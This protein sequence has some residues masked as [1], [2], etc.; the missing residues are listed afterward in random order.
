MFHLPPLQACWLQT[1][2]KGVPRWGGI[3]P[4]GLSFP[5]VTQEG[6][7]PAYLSEPTSQ[8]LKR[9]PRET[10]KTSPRLMPVLASR[11]R[12]QLHLNVF[13][14]RNEVAQIYSLRQCPSQLHGVVCLTEQPKGM[15]DGWRRRLQDLGG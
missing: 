11:L 12:A 2:G 6:K 8:C 15:T 9:S 13:S 10:P 14:A 5:G 1:D 3:W 4:A 7:S